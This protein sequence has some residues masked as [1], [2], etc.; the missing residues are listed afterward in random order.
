MNNVTNASLKYDLKDIFNADGFG[1]FY[2]CLPNKTYHFKGQKCSGEKNSKV[3]LTGMVAGNAIG[4]KRPMFVIGKSKTPRCFKHK[5]NLPYKYKSQKKS[6]MD[7]HIF[8]E[9]VRKLDRK[10]PMEGRKILLLIDDCPAHPSV[11][12][13]T[14]VQL[15]FLPPNTT[16]VLQPMDQD[17][18]RSLKVHYRGKAV[19]RLCR[20]FD[21]MKTLP[22]ISILQAMKILVSSWEAASAQIIVNYFKNAGLTPEAQTA[23]ITDADNPFSNLKE[24]LEQL[25]DI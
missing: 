10:F 16:S 7:S 22:K 24:S 6:R 20:A 13:L 19:R 9:W 17:V 2:Q 25:L 5:K 1:L 12:N 8:E 18:I 4:E 23:G 21:K 14:N 11:S 3:R 15:V